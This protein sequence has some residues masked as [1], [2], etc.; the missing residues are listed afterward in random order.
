MT[1]VPSTLEAVSSNVL[2][3][4]SVSCTVSQTVVRV[5][6]MVQ[7]PMFMV[8]EHSKKNLNDKKS[9]FS[10]NKCSYIK[11]VIKPFLFI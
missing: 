9:K 5:P 8:R 3:M 4:Q 10:F 1:E 6:Q 2:P 11:N 7:E